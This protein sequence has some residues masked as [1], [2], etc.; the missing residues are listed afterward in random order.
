M[1]RLPYK[2]AWKRKE[3]RSEDASASNAPLSVKTGVIIDP[4][5]LEHSNQTDEISQDV[6]TSSLSL[7]AESG[8]MINPDSPENSN[9]KLP[10]EKKR[11]HNNTQPVHEYRNRH[12]KKTTKKFARIRKGASGKVQRYSLLHVLMGK[13]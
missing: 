8:T 5:S 12:R 1:L 4:D 9:E 3:K 2:G 10:G 7:S 6:S 11:Q 13:E